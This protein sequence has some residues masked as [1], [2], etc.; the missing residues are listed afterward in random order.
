MLTPQCC[1]ITAN[2]FGEVN[3]H[4]PV[5]LRGMLVITSMAVAVNMC[6]L[7]Q[8]ALKAKRRGGK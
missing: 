8:T 6:T 3:N 5:I 2:R 1:S 4:L 7:M